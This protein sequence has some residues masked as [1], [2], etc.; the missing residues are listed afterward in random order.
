MPSSDGALAT[1]VS[2]ARGRE[3]LHRSKSAPLALADFLRSRC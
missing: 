1:F 3:R 2:V